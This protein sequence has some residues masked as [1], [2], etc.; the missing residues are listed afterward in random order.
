MTGKNQT[1]RRGFLKATAAGTA[2]LTAGAGKALAAK[3]AWPNVNPQIDNL[4]VVCC[5]DTAM[6]TDAGDWPDDGKVDAQKVFDNMDAMA[7]ALANET[8]A[9]TAWG[10]VL[11]EHE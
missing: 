5:H 1:T 8:D 11:P 7:M 3:Q 2:A 10:K 4:R 6:A 9:A